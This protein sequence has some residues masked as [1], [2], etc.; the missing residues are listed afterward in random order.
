MNHYEHSRLVLAQRIVAL[1]SSKP[2]ETGMVVRFHDGKLRAAAVA[3]YMSG[4]AASLRQAWEATAAFDNPALAHEAR[5]LQA[6][7]A[8]S[9]AM[10]NLLLAAVSGDK[11]GFKEAFNAFVNDAVESGVVAV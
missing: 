2:K 8:A 3:K 7:A 4:Q 5:M 11:Q 9:E 1:F 10:S 6:G